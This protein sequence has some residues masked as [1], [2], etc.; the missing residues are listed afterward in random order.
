MERFVGWR[1]WGLGAVGLLLVLVPLLA[2]CT[3][4]SPVTPAQAAAATVPVTLAANVAIPACAQAGPAI[5]PPAAFPT[6]FP[7][8]P[9]MVITEGQAQAKGRVALS[10]YVPTDV[11][12]LALYMNQTL[13]HAGY[14]PRFIEIETKDA[15][16]D[17]D[18]PTGSQGRWKVGRI[19]N[20]PNAVTLTVLIQP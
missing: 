5:A 4:A 7:L 3:M 13:P 17:F 8:P 11:R 16:G 6:D 15:E 1:F 18:G 19:V 20:C 14:T 2:G 9:S 10:G 12:T